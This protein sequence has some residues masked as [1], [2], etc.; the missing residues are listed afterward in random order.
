MRLGIPMFSDVLDKFVPSPAETKI[1]NA[2]KY[3]MEAESGMLADRHH[4]A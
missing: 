2:S 1:M 3:R 4:V